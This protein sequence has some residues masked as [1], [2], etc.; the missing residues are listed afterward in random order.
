[1]DQVAI[2]CD[3]IDGPVSEG[4][5][6]LFIEPGRTD[7]EGREAYANPLA[8]TMRAIDPWRSA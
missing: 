2:R 8:A 4:S 7:Q 5:G 6:M 3:N 1:M